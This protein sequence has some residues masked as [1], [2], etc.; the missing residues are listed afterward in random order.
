MIRSMNIGKIDVFGGH[1]M[2]HIFKLDKTARKVIVS[3]YIIAI[4]CMIAYE[5][6]HEIS[7]IITYSNLCR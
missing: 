6:S 2:N 7:Y 5:I 4:L 3:I 1:N